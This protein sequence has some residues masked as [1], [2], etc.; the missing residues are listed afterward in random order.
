MVARVF[1]P[2]QTEANLFFFFFITFFIGP[3]YNYKAESGSHSPLSLNS[4]AVLLLSL[5]VG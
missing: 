5:L 2:R 4:M 3:K 1:N